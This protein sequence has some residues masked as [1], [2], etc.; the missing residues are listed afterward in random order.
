[1]IYRLITYLCILTGSVQLAAKTPNIIF[2]LADD[3][4]PGDVG[5]YHRRFAGTEAKVA[6]PHMD[7]LAKEGMSFTD[8]QLPAA[9]CAPN[10]FCILTGNY[11]F[12]SIPW[13]SWFSTGHPALTYGP[14]A[15]DRAKNPHQTVGGLLQKV[16][17]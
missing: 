13:G 1:M 10:R 8:A 9:L 11:T 17:Y 7:R 2:L 15:G 4:G 12:R 3:L 5:T 16:G 6:T 14:K